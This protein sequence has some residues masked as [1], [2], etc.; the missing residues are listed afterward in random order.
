MSSALDDNVLAPKYTFKVV[1]EPQEIEVLAALVE[2]G[3]S[4][5]QPSGLHFELS[6]LKVDVHA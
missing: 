6:A 5:C 2:V 3:A 4:R 1:M